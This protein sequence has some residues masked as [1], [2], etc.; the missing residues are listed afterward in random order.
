MDKDLEKQYKLD[1]AQIDEKEKKF[2]DF[3]TEL[4]KISDKLKLTKATMDDEKVQEVVVIFDN[5]LA[6]LRSHVEYLSSDLYSFMRQ[7]LKGHIPPL[8]SKEQ[9]ERAI[10]ALG[11]DKEYTVEKRTVYVE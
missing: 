11:L 1:L 4:D 7:H 6:N 3:G 10:K 8:K 2:A 5:A 9:L